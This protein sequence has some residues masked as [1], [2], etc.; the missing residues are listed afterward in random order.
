MKDLTADVR[1]IIEATQWLTTSR[2]THTGYRYGRQYVVDQAA[3]TNDG[4]R[5]SPQGAY[6]GR[7]EVYMPDGHLQT[8]GSIMLVNHGDG[9]SYHDCIPVTYAPRDGDVHLGLN[10]S[11]AINMRQLTAFPPEQLARMAANARAVMAHYG[12]VMC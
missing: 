4:S 12:A 10:S 9:A 5:P 6:F 1:A 8:R 7:T 11:E 3:T 2:D